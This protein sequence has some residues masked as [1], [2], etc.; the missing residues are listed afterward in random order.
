V[1][2]FAASGEVWNSGPKQVVG[3]V[4]GVPEAVDLAAAA[5]GNLCQ[6]FAS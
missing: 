5:A 6:A 3:A 2:W 1:L 4:N